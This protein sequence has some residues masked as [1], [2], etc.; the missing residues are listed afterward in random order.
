MKRITEQVVR[1]EL[2]PEEV[3]LAL[4][5]KLNEGGGFPNIDATVSFSPDGGA[6]ITS[7]FTEGTKE[8]KPRLTA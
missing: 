5:E 7:V 4:L 3:K 8:Q 2:S 6:V 1:Y